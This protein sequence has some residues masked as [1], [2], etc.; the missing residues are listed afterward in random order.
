MRTPDELY[1]E[2]M[3]LAQS[4]NLDGAATKWEQAGEHK[5]AMFYLAQM[6]EQNAFSGAD[7]NKAIELY[8]ALVNVRPWAA[9]KLGMMYCRGKEP[10]GNNPYGN[11]WAWNP[12]KAKELIEKFEGFARNNPDALDGSDWLNLGEAYCSGRTI[13]HD[14]PIM[15]ITEMELNKAIQFFEWALETEGDIGN[16]PRSLVVNQLENQIERRNLLV[17]TICAACGGEAKVAPEPDPTRP[18]YCSDCYV[19]MKS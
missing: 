9:L 7:F 18:Y 17:A 2:G 10:N 8:S 16:V 12:E 6:H 14:D 15:D 11:P 4:G 1:Q 19:Q 5:E 3:A 13:R